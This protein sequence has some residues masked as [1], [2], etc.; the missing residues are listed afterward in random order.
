[1]PMSRK[2]PET[3]EIMTP[4]SIGRTKTDLVLGKHSGRAAVKSKLEELGYNLD[5]EQLVIVVDALKK[6]ADRKEKIY[7]ED[8]E[9][10]VLEEVYR[11]PDQY[12][13]EDMSVNCA[14]AG[15]PPTAAV[16]MQVRGESRRFASF[17][18][19]PVDAVFNTI[20]SIIGASPRLH[21]YAVNAITRGTD[22]QG[23]V[24]VRLEY[25]KCTAVGRGSDPDILVASAK[26][27]INALNR[28]EM[29]NEV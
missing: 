28:L 1:M 15:V 14:T 3:Y 21:R 27:Y 20:N 2:N 26:A 8:V 5:E 25:N 7:D 22:A 6:L 24:T 29:K 11:L 13:L 10:L 18:A 16:V 23:E 4:E 9:A 19:G 12:K 17:G